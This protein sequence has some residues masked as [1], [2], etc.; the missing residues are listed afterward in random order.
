MVTYLGRCLELFSIYSHCWV[1]SSNLMAKLQVIINDICLVWTF[2]LK[3]RPIHPIHFSTLKFTRHFK[4][5]MPYVGL[6]IVPT[7]SAC[8][9]VLHISVNGK[10]VLSVTQAQILN[11]FWLSYD[12]SP[13]HFISRKS[14]CLYI[15]SI[16]RIWPF[17]LTSLLPC[18]SKSPS[19]PNWSLL[20]PSFSLC[21]TQQKDGFLSL[22]KQERTSSLWQVRWFSPPYVSDFILSTFSTPQVLFVVPGPP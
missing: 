15:Q 8:F 3:S 1:I 2:S 6:L 22:F 18:W 20:H 11:S 17:L 10:S 5:N 19:S 7:K 21:T 16:S 4:L 13:S 12:S 14:Y 9:I